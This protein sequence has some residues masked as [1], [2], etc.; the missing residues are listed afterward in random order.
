M[1]N[2]ETAEWQRFSYGCLAE[3]CSLRVL[4]AI[5][6]CIHS[7]IPDVI[8]HSNMAPEIIAYQIFH[9]N[10]EENVI[11]IINFASVVFILCFLKVSMSF[12]IIIV[13]RAGKFAAYGLHGH[14]RNTGNKRIL[15]IGGC[16]ER[17]V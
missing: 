2:V 14:R 16:C 4:L 3:V 12:S 7:W 9:F 10:P 11:K 13:R 15:C 1:L 8:E 5:K 6:L 17:H